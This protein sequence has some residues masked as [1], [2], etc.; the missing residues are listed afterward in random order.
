MTSLSLCIPV[1]RSAEFL[2]DLFERLLALEPKPVEVLLLDD[3]SPDRSAALIRRFAEGAVSQINL[4]VIRNAC[5]T[6]IAAA[7]NRLAAEAR[8][9]WVHIL[10]ADDY[11]LEVDFYARV[12]AEFDP[13][14][15]L[16]VTALDSNSRVLRWG[17]S[18]LGWMIPRHPPRWLPILGSFATRAGVIYRRAR[19]LAHPFPDPAF[20]GSDVLHLLG[21][22]REHN[23]LF[24]HHAHVFYRVHGDATSS[25]ARSYRRYRAGL[26]RFGR[27]TRFAHILDLRL[28]MLGQHIVRRRP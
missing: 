10:D 23:C 19:L 8:G 6:G 21:L 2:P 27:S 5:N 9:E 16:L 25:R 11:P 13:N 26:A 12:A 20:P 15:D 7:Y 28:R 3:A 14:L 1:Y 18:T 22:R 24:M 4:R 17:V